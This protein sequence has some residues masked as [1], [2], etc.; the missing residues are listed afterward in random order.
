MHG[1]AGAGGAD[2]GRLAGMS[3]LG[4]LVPVVALLVLGHLARRW[5]LLDGAAAAGLNRLVANLALPALLLAKIGTS[6]LD[7]NLSL[8]LM[9]VTVGGTVLVAALAWAA[10]GVARLPGP[11]RGVMAQAAMRGN[12][13]YLS[14]PLIL[15][16]YGDTGLRLAAVT[17][18][19][20]IPVMNLLG[21]LVLIHARPEQTGVGRTLLRLVF[22][23]L[24]ASALAGLG[25]AA[26][27]WEPWPWL[28]T[29]LRTLGDFALPGALLALGSQLQPG[30]VGGVWRL[31]ATATAA[32][33]V[34][35]PALGLWVLSAWHLPP[36]EVAV[37]VLMLAAPTAI[38]SYPVAV[39][40]GGDAD[41][42]GACV[43]VST[44]ACV[45]SYAVWKLLLPAV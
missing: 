36:L 25:L 43:L 15:T 23:P 14:F 19:V 44:L 22:N 17:A 34:L 28:G 26:L 7:E 9:F 16:S 1:A 12:I 41:L 42:A 30:R 35:L 32:K 39:D 6:P 3:V 5:G 33:L 40:L 18:S 37:G 45:L 4:G 13:A 27:G 31:A 2:S 21:A 10:G 8:P 29:T 20:L 11:R 24:V 38:A